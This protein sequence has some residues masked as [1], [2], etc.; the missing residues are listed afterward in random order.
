MPDNSVTLT[1]GEKIKNIRLEKRITLEE[2][3]RHT[4]LTPSFISQI[5]RNL[6]SPSVQSLHKIAI[7]LGSKISNFFEENDSKGLVLL[8]KN[9]KQNIPVKFQAYTIRLINDISSINLHPFVIILD[10]SPNAE[11]E[12]PSH[13]EDEFG[14]VIKG[15]IL[16]S[17]NKVTYTME[18]GDCIYL[19][20]PGKHK[21]TNIGNKKV[22]VLWI[23][24]SNF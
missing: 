21:I 14:I 8:K 17:I 3:A 23:Y 2:V 11:K 6:A 24:G 10:N 15:K 5:E 13:S 12:L 9:Y 22:E 19:T 16:L 4:K 7:A 18:E 20:S 1:L